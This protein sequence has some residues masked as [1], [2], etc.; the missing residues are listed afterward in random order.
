MAEVQMIINLWNDGLT[1]TE[2]GERIGKSR[3]AILGKV[4][5]LR[6]KGIELERRV[7]DREKTVKH[8]GSGK[9]RKNVIQLHFDGFFAPARPA[10]D[11][12][13]EEP[14]PE[15]AVDLFSLKPD[16]CHYIVGREDD[17]AM[18]CGGASFRRSMCKTHHA[19]CYYRLKA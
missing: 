2:I 7:P 9:P 12:V 10:P 3:S 15:N 18:Y 8:R 19:L 4:N 5:R 11:P 14:V 1:A 13:V 16:Q 17:M 6:S